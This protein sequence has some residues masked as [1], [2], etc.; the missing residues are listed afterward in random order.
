MPYT[1]AGQPVYYVDQ[2]GCPVNP[3]Q[4]PMQYQTPT[5]IHPGSSH[6]YFY[7]DHLLDQLLRIFYETF[8]FSFYE[9]QETLLVH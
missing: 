3:Q 2:N 6:Q 7:L 5:D 4:Q 9:F 1:Q 8:V